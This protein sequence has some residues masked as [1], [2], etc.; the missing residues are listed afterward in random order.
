MTRRNEARARHSSR[1]ARWHRIALYAIGAGVWLTGALWLLFHYVIVHRNP[2]GSS[3][4]PWWLTLHGGFAFATIWM[5]GLLWG[6]HVPA[7]WPGGRRRV[8]GALLV[9]SLGSLLITGYLLYYVGD[10]ELRAV[11]SIAH[12]AV[13]LALPIGFLTHRQRWSRKSSMTRLVSPSRRHAGA[14]R[15]AGIAARR[16]TGDRLDQYSHSP[17]DVRC[18]TAREA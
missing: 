18:E 11:T 15:A 4:E 5:F 10:E 3:S 7:R 13:G 2:F 1:L 9:G 16:Q 6:V 8:S 12:W 17:T 14:E